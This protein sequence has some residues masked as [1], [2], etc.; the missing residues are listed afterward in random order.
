MKIKNTE[1]IV[2]Q[3]D[4]TKAKTK[5]VVSAAD[6][7][8]S[9]AAGVAGAIKKMGGPGIQKEAQARGAVIPGQAVI[10]GGGKLP[11]SYVIHAVTMKMP[12]EGEQA[13]TD[14]AIVR[15]ATYSALVCAQE[16]L[17]S[18]IAFCALGCGRGGL[19]YESVSK[20][21]AQ[22]I[23]R[24]LRR[25]ESA[26]LKKI[27]FVV[28]GKQAR[29]IFDKNVNDYLAYMEKKISQGPFLTVDGIISYQQGIVMVKRSNPPFGWAL[30]GGF[31]D[32]EESVE[33][34]VIR[35]VKEETGLDFI[36]IRQ[37]R[38]YSKAD[39][40]PRFHTVSVVFTGQGQ[41]ILQADSDAQAAEAFGLD[42]LPQ[43]IAF[44]H[45]EI[46]ADYIR[47]KS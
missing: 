12:A 20:I 42:D 22:E 11:A 16:K 26:S 13:Y 27:A 33:D 36:D 34:A 43:D 23:F 15:K 9:M 46:I 4:I 31:V 44:D 25:Y 8:F 24:Y 18:S 35:E 45:R 19:P 1:V 30:P 14:Y 39:R 47:S 28:H 3:G 5:A 10:T 6:D 38:V 21:M 29:R 40:D 17:I 2:M 37:F 41:G 7:H 32:Y